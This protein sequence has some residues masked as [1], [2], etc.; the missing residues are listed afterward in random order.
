MFQ[1]LPRGSL[2]EA[3]P[4]QIVGLHRSLNTPLVSLDGGEAV[5]C[6]AYTLGVYKL[7]GSYTLFVVLKALGSSAV[8][9]FRSE[10]T[11]IAIADYRHQEEGALELVKRPAI[12]MER[13]ELSAMTDEDRARLMEELPLSQGVE[14]GPSPG[15]GREGAG[16]FGRAEART[17]KKV[18]DVSKKKTEGFDLGISPEEAISV[19]GRLLAS[20]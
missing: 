9:L 19:L 11:G 6:R 18:G 20:F 10:Q 2:I 12:V 5:L 7:S 13:I 3:A 8:S 14:P 15:M 17:E 1:A 4:N 16:D